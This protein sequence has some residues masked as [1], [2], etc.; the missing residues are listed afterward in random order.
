M[1]ALGYLLLAV[2]VGLVVGYVAS[3]VVPPSGPPV[4][5]VAGE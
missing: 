1:K 3:L 4:T 5:Y 2:L